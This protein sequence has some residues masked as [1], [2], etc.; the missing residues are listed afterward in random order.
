MDKQVK[1]DS[2]GYHTSTYRIFHFLFWMTTSNLHW[3]WGRVKVKSFTIRPNIFL[4]QK[5]FIKLSWL[6]FFFGYFP[7]LHQNRQ[8]QMLD[9]FLRSLSPNLFTILRKGLPPN[10]PRSS[11][12]RV[13]P[14]TCLIYVNGL[15]RFEAGTRI[16]SRK[17]NGSGWNWEK[18]R[19]ISNG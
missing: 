16:L 2:D 11:E 18:R 7:C 5:M 8:T 17:W 4:T 14:S 19:K 6:H 1:F 10:A 13:S 15:W 12:H 9:F 3:F